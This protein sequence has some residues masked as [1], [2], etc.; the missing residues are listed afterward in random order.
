[1]FFGVFNSGTKK[2]HSM[3]RGPQSWTNKLDGKYNWNIWRGEPGVSPLS[4]MT[5]KN[6]SDDKMK[7]HKDNFYSWEE[8]QKS[9]AWSYCLLD[10]IIS[11]G[12]QKHLEPN[13]WFTHSYVTLK[14]KTKWLMPF[15][16]RVLN[17]SAS[18]G[19][20]VTPSKS[21]I[22]YSGF[23]CLPQVLLERRISH[24]VIA[25]TTIILYFY[26]YSLIKM[27]VSYIPSFIFQTTHIR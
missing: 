12:L 23:L 15:S 2:G 18:S 22:Q 7:V 26:Y 3:Q 14:L 9:I 19:L 25:I 16:L 11:T 13:F 8:M 20:E 1:M 5:L 24:F 17:F 27:S 10:I 6:L 21:S 4:L